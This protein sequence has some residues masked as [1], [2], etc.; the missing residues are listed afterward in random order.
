MKK[1]II[2]FLLFLAFQA[3]LAENFY[4]DLTPKTCSLG[5]QV[6]LILKIPEGLKD[7]KIKIISEKVNFSDQYIYIPKTQKEMDK[8]IVGKATEEGTG[9]VYVTILYF[10]NGSSFIGTYRFSIN[11]VGSKEKSLVEENK[12]EEKVEKNEKIEESNITV[13][14]TL[15]NNKTEINKTKPINKSEVN[16]TGKLNITIKTEENN[17]EVIEVNYIIY[18]ILGLISGGIFGY[19]LGYV[20]NIKA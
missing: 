8:V 9:E 17:K 6:Y 2:M 10:K 18:A 3:T 4:V 15:I 13:N 19:L 14:N 20:I 11:I 5:D 16:L 1:L 12:T 7:I